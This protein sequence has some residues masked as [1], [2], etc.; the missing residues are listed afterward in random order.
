[1]K[2]GS[3]RH[4]VR[5]MGSLCYIFFMQKRGNERPSSSQLMKFPTQL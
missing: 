5:K 4:D 2:T 3:P 1:M